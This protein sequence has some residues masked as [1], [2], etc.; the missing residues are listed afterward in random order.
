V[1]V[2]LSPVAPAGASAAGPERTVAARRRVDPGSVLAWLSVGPALVV[3]GWLLAAYPLALAGRATPLLAV[4]AA[5]PLVLLLTVAARR[6]PAVPATPWWSVLGTLAVTGAFAW[7][8]AT[9]A[10]G[11]LVLRR[12]SAVY[13]L[14]ARWIADTGALTVP[15]GLGLVGGTDATVGA[16]APGLYPAG[17]VLSAQ[18][19]S[20]TA[21]TLAPAGWAGGWGPV[22]AAPALVAAFALLAVAGLAARLLGARWAPAAALALGLTQPVLLTARS[23]YSEPLAQLLLSAALCLLL[24]AVRGP[25]RRLAALAGLL[26]GIGLLVRIDA[27]RE[28]ALLVPVAGWLALRRD[29]AWPPLVGGAAVG[30]AYGVVDALGPARPYVADLWPSVR[31][32]LIAAVGLVALAVLAVPVGRWLA[33]GLQAGP[34]WDRS[35]L[36]G[37]AV[38]ALGVAAAL[39]VLAGRRFGWQDRGGWDGYGA[40]GTFLVVEALQRDQGLPVDG[41]RTYAEESVRWVSWFV[42]WPALGLA[43]VAAVLLTW[44]AVRGGPGAREAGRWVL[45]LAVP[46]ASALSVLWRPAITPDHPWADRRLVPTVL[47]VVVLL[48]LWTVSALAAAARRGLARSG[49]GAARLAAAVVVAAGLAAVLLPADAGSRPLRDTR[50]EVG[51]PA[52]LESVCRVFA[53]GDVALLID[54]RGRQEWTAALREAC[55]VPAFV[56]PA[57]GTDRTATREEATT[58]VARVRAAGGRPVLVAQ[59]GEPLPRLTSAPQRQ[60]VDLD[61]WEHRRLLEGSP[62]GLAPLSIELWVALP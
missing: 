56:V 21:L 22:L 36:V 5:V 14:L 2:D 11:H 44:R 57:E 37:A 53:P 13:A 28:L 31:P 45:G 18:F 47:P 54:A 33:P 61:T 6:L 32:A 55:G 51:E 20:G 35:R 60:V 19:M 26:T 49:P 23:T 12:D 24:D 46:L 43:A 39:G 58:A 16:A 40:G 15:A 30:I 41:N 62:R 25:D 42:G 50:T 27:L 17:D 4:P 38:A 3:A 48:A 52:A 59:S 7:H 8:T 1:G 9:H 29:P 34:W 10:S